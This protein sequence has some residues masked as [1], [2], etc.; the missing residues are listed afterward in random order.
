MEEKGFFRRSHLAQGVVEQE[1]GLVRWEAHPESMGKPPSA[2]AQGWL[3]HGAPAFL[4]H[5]GIAKWGLSRG[6]AV[7][8]CGG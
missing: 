1:G 2:G 3:W 5:F 6:D 4:Q 7:S 8:Y